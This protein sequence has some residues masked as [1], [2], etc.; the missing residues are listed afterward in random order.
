MLFK[1][2]VARAEIIILLSLIFP[3]VV[4]AQEVLQQKN[5]SLSFQLGKTGLIYNLRFDH[6]IE[7]KNIIYNIS[8]GSNFAKY[9]NLLTVGG[10][11]GYLFG[12]RNSF[13]ETEL[14]V[15]YLVVDEVS[16]D[17]GFP[18]IF[19]DY[20]IKTVYINVDIGYRRYSK[21]GIFRFGVSPGFIK[22][23]FLPGGYISYGFRF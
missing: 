22:N 20:S 3:S 21:R 18:L 11:A 1:R 16:D 10:G 5:N 13:L 6:K 9:L 14:N 15:N 23:D 7:N 2:F 4:S 12:R 8:A 19:P 17:Q